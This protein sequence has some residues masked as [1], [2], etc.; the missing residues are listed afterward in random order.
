MRKTVTTITAERSAMW[1]DD[2]HG[3]PRRLNHQP[4]GRPGSPTETSLTPLRRGFS[5]G[6]PGAANVKRDV[7]YANVI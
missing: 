3:E 4:E 7:L 1:K 2:D 5:F 6:R